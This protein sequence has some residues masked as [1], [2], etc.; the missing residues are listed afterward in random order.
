VA[1]IV[2]TL[3]FCTGKLQKNIRYNFFCYKDSI[4][5]LL[6]YKTTKQSIILIYKNSKQIVILFISSLV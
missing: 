2:D 4:K 6:Y 3:C 5:F 1:E